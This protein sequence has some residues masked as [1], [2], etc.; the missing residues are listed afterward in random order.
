MLAVTRQISEQAKLQPNATALCFGDVDLSYGALQLR[1]HHFAEYLRRR[2]RVSDGA[3]AICLERSV[4]RV[5]AAL[6]VMRAGAAYVPLDPTWP[7][8]RIRYAVE[9]FEAV[10]L[11]ARTSTLERLQLTLPGIDPCRDAA[12]IAEASGVTDYEASPETLA[13]VIYTSGQL[14]CR[15][16]LRL[17]MRT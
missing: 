11:V 13:Y 1:T 7:E 3:V 6:A 15:K 16:E 17:L 10:A 9:D 8:A 4:D 2:A 14:G 12:A 5:V